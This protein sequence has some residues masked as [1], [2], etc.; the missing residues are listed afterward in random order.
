LPPDTLLE[1]LVALAHARWVIKQFYEDARAANV[2]WTTSRGAAS[3]VC[4][5]I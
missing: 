5:G 4:I 3:M 2:A 1:L